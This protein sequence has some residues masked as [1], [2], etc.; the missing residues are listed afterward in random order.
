[1]IERLNNDR[2][3]HIP[4]EIWKIEKAFQYSRI[5]IWNDTPMEVRE[6]SSLAVITSPFQ[7]KVE[8]AFTVEPQ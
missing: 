8:R 2:D 1:M 7:G 4:N 6:L 3:L 5:K